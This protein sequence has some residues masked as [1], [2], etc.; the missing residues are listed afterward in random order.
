MVGSSPRRDEI[1]GGQAMEFQI[2]SSDGHAATGPLRPAERELPNKNEPIFDQ[3][4]AFDLETL[5]LDRRQVIKFIGSAGVAAGLF[6][7]AG[8]TPSGV[9]SSPSGAASTTSSASSSSSNASCDTIPEETAG[10]Y[11]GDGSNGPDVLNQSGIVRSDIRSS[12]GSSSGTAE[13]VPLTIKLSIMDDSNG[14]APLASAA[15]Y[16][17]HCDRDGRYSMYSQGVTDQNYLRGVQGADSEGLV[18]FQSIFPGAYSGRWPHIHFEVY[19]SLDKAT[20]PANKIATSQ[21]ALPKDACDTVYATTGYS[22]SVTNLS[23]T[24]LATDNV[25]GDDGGAH[26]LGTVGGSVDSGLTVELAVPVKT[27]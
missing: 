12:F 11:P 17:W 5:V 24:S 6:A 13:G 9:V 26:Q 22:Q 2:R 4:L 19:P 15:V 27:A 7:I 18:T 14:C 25:F 20:D 23:Q 21:I 10:P 16:V 1:D 3:G 8:C